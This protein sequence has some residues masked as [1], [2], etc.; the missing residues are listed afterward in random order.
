MPDDRRDP[1]A[2]NDLIDELTQ[3]ATPSHA[4]T[5]GGA[6]Q[7]DLADRDELKTATGADP[8]PTSVHKGDK[9]NHGDEPTLPNR[10]GGGGP[11]GS[12]SAEGGRGMSPGGG[13]G[14]IDGDA[15]SGRSGPEP[16]RTS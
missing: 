6:M 12:A 1:H 5:A 11:Q 16:R 7:R 13:G 3:E 10:D 8:L 9:P 15:E 4:G 14:G 2:D